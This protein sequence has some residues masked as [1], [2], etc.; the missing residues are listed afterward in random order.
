M[1]NWFKPSQSGL[2]E[3]AKMLGADR[4]SYDTDDSESRRRMT[5]VYPDGERRVCILPIDC[6][7][8]T[9][10]YAILYER[11]RR[12]RIERRR[13]LSARWATTWWGI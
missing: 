13:T 12:D 1:A 10:S 11:E 2:K 3:I 8:E 7:F 6:D 4:V 5:V 9:L